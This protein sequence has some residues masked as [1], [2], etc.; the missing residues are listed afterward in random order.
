M[1][2]ITIYKDECSLRVQL[3]SEGHAGTAEAGRDLVCAAVSSHIYGYAEAIKGLDTKHLGYR[4]VVAGEKPGLADVD[5]VCLNE[6][7]FRRVLHFLV[8]MERALELLEQEYP[9]AI[10]L[11]RVQKSG[12]PTRV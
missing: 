1:I 11:V 12:P 2:E 10:H 4:L 5:V 3:Y 8:P 9:D 6:R 7:I